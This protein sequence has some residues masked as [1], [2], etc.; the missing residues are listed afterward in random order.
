MNKLIFEN[1]IKRLE[2]N[3]NN[4]VGS[5]NYGCLDKN[6]WHYKTL[7][8]FPSATYQQP[9]LGLALMLS[10]DSLKFNESEYTNLVNMYKSSFLYWVKIQNS[11]GSFNEYYENDCSFCPTAFTTYAA[12]RSFYLKNDCFDCNER[13]LIEKALT[14]SS[15]WL[16]KNT[17]SIVGNQMITSTAALYFIDKIFNTKI[18]NDIYQ[19]RK[20]H[21]IKL[22]NKEGWFS[23]YGGADIGYSLL[24]LDVLAAMARDGEQDCFE[25]GLK[26]FKFVTS[27]IL[28]DGKVGGILNSRNTSHIFYFGY[29][30]FGNRS[31]LNYRNLIKFCINNTYLVDEKYFTYFYFNQN[32]EYLL[33]QR[34]LL[35]AKDFTDNLNVFME[36]SGLYK[37][38]YLNISIFISANLGG[39]FYLYRGEEKLYS[40]AGYILKY[41]KK[42]YSNNRFIPSKISI[43]KLKFG[44]VFYISSVLSNPKI[45]TPLVRYIVLFKFVT[46]YLLKIKP[47]AIIFNVLLKFL[48]VYKSNAT[49]IIFKRK[50]IIYRD[51]MFIKD[52]I[53]VNNR[54]RILMNGDSPI[55]MHSPSS[56]REA[57]YTNIISP[58]TRI[59]YNNTYIKS[60]KT[61]NLNE[62]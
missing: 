46:K 19:K 20:K 13:K 16:N 29:Y 35:E 37:I 43:K 53:N 25:M 8:D 6:F 58:T 52:I 48:L 47:L 10:S 30:Y 14:L 50:I 36:N 39:A 49:N 45:K 40:D 54:F 59:E 27:F 22:Q 11:D 32:V 38:H 24:S 44:Y 12:S 51:K 28:P 18:S 42:L 33:N 17:Y 41:N 3:H 7:I 31:S 4:L 57:F 9:I 61:F 15:F 56:L 62:Q 23:E 21:L 60:L 2:Q 55:T 5:E 34:N 26:L 1:L